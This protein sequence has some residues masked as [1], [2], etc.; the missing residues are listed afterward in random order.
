MRVIDESPGTD[1]ERM[2]LRGAAERV[3]QLDGNQG[4]HFRGGH[5]QGFGLNLHKWRRE[6]R[7]DVHW[8]A[9]KLLGAKEHQHRGDSNHQVAKTYARSDDPTHHC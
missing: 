1:F 6:L 7:K 3:F 4:F 2:E 5:P 8:H 9:A